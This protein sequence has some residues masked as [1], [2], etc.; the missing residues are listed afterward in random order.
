MSCK[1]P[2]GWCYRRPDCR[3][4]VEASGL[5]RSSPSSVADAPLPSNGPQLVRL[6]LLMKRHDELVEL[7]AQTE[8][9]GRA[10]RN[11]VKSI[12][13]A[14]DRVQHEGTPIDWRRVKA[15]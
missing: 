7:M 8:Q 15:P 1:C 11:A 4:E 3:L 6:E 9:P 5:E 10:L 12:A 14:I 13:A 2:K